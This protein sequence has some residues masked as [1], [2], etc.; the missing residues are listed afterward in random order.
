MPAGDKE[1]EDKVSPSSSDGDDDDII[2]AIVLG[3]IFGLF[4]I[5]L[6]IS[7]YC[8][9]RR[10]KRCGGMALFLLFTVLAHIS[11]MSDYN[12]LI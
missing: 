2:P 3:S 6:I 1:E 4:I 9:C 11:K 10:K 7:L 5:I 12:V 8:F